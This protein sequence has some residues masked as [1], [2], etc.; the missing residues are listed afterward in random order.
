M[1]D[2]IRFTFKD[3]TL[4]VVQRMNCSG[5]KTEIRIFVTV[6]PQRAKERC[7]LIEDHGS[8]NGEKTVK[9]DK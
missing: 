8:V 1:S 2:S 4:A 5:A 7:C 3:I 9:I 6:L